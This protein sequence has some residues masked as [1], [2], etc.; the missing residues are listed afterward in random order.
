M[1]EAALRA[2]GTR[3]RQQAWE[4]LQHDHTYQRHLRKSVKLH[5]R[6]ELNVTSRDLPIET[7]LS[8]PKHFEAFLLY[9]ESHFCSEPILVR[10]CVAGHCRRAC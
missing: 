5:K 7:V 2:E 9:A 3:M 4:R 1:S 6:F 10:V 8:D